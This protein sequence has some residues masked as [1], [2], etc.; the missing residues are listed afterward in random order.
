MNRTTGFLCATAMAAIYAVVPAASP[1]WAG[2]V[3]DFYKTHNIT[4]DVGFGAGGGYDVTTRI[5]ARHFGKHVPGNPTVLVQNMPG[6]GSMKVANFVYNA[7]PKDGSV[8]GVFASS[9]ALEP[10]FGNKQAKYDPRKFDWI[11]SMHRDVA[12]CGVWKGSGIN[13]L[14]DLIKSKKTIMFG[15]TSPTAITSQHPLFLK[16]MF[17][18]NL[19]VIYGY[20]GTKDVNL[21]MQ[22]GELNGSCGMFVSSVQGAFEQYVKSGDFKI[23]AQ[24]GHKAVPAFKNATV[25][26]DLLKTDEQRKIADVIFGQTELARPLAAPPGTPKDRVAALR[27]ALLETMKDPALIADGKKIHVKFEPVSGEEA[28]QMFIDW[29][30]TPPALVKKARAYTQPDKS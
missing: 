20:K 17:G 22:R 16:H 10:L 15:S 9:T 8:L 24:F 3:A 29:Y 12:S 27:K 25:M 6:A 11:G 7:A 23:I 5:V 19:K 14:Q 28:T 2:D 26:Y 21:A 18:A 1:A 13:S 4:I 30:K